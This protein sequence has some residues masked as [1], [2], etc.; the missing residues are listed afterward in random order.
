MSATGAGEPASTSAPWSVTASRSTS[1][2][3]APWT[4]AGSWRASAAAARSRSAAEATAA[5]SRRD[6]PGG[7]GA[8]GE[9]RLDRVRVLADHADHLGGQAVRRSAR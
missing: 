8:R 3:A 1:Q 2:R 4:A 5:S 6:A 9:E 7:A